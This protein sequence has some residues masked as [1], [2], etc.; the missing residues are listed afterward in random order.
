ARRYVRP[1][2]RTMGVGKAVAW[3]VDVAVVGFHVAPGLLSALGIRSWP[4]RL[5]VSV[6]LVSLTGL[7]AG[8][9]FDAWR[10]LSYDKR[11]GFSTQTVRGFVSD[12]AKGLLVGVVV[13][14]LLA[15]PLWALIRATAAW[16]VYG[17]VVV[18]AL[19]IGLAFLGPLLILPLFNRFTPLGDDGL[20]ADL[21]GLARDVGADV[22][23]VLVSD[24]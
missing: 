21:L 12:Q 24:A 13:F 14:T 3:A 6:V 7:A 1:L 11:W 16:W 20:R 23:E 19:G 17:W 18:V 4:A 10:E 9:G 8:A 2:R 22:S 5:A 15:F